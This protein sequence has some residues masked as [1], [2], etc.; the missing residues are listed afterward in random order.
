MCTQNCWSA[1][2]LIETEWAPNV[3][4]F[5]NRFHPDVIREGPNRLRN[6]YFTYLV[7]LRA[8][9]KAAPYL[10]RQAFYTGDE[11]ADRNA[12]HAV[13]DLLNIIQ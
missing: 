1:G 5:K 2:G 6:L 11:L 4:E 8:L 13:Y 9:A 7:E 12:R 10:K 3:K